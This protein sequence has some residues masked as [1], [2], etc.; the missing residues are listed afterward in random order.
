MELEAHRAKID[1]IDEAI[2]ELI[3]ERMEIVQ[4]I[5]KIKQALKLP[6]EDKVREEEILKRLEELSKGK[7]SNDQLRATFKLII[8]IC[9]EGQKSV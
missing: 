2:L 7:V 6:I 4:A 9:L 1:S 3:H 5:G 8:C